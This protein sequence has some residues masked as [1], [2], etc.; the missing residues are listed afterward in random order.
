MNFRTSRRISYSLSTATKDS[1][2]IERVPVFAFV[3]PVCVIYF[4]DFN[5]S[6]CDDFYILR[7]FADLI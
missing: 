4:N 2:A 5:V 7:L 6:L 3:G 1:D